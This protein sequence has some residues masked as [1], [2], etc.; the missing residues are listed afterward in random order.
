MIDWGE[1]SDHFIGT[2]AAILGLIAAGAT[3]GASVYAANKSSG[4]AETAAKLQTDAANHAADVQSKSTADALAFQRQ[5]AENEWLNS[6]NTQKANYEQSKAR[7]GSIAG[8]ASQYGL[9]LAGMPDYAPGVDPHYT[10]PS[11]PAPGTVAGAAGAPPSAPGNLSDPTAWMSLVGNKPALAQWVTSQGITDPS[12]VNYYVGKIQGQ[13]GANP[14]EQAGSAT[15]WSQKIKSDPSL[16]G[17]AG[18]VAGAAKTPYSSMVA[19]I[20]TPIAPTTAMPT[21]YQPGT[22]GAQRRIY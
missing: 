19:P 11:T 16:G 14:T 13:P 7:Y 10:D 12:L 22:I 4:A 21:P 15:Y 1:Q 8:V 3:T 5:Q 18:T 9:N 2:T 20:Q 17:G 6:Q